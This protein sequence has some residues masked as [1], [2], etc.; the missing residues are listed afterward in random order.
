MR[1]SPS[2]RGSDSRR[3]PVTGGIGFW[4]IPEERG[5]ISAAPSPA[6]LPERNPFGLYLYVDDV[7]AVAERVR[8]LIIEPGGPHEKPSGMYELAVSDPN[9]TLVRVGREAS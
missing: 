7:D 8:E 4:K 1:R 6:G 9:G 2:T 5:C 3:S